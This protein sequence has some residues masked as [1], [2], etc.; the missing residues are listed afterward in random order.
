MTR[1]LPDHQMANGERG[2]DARAVLRYSGIFAAIVVPAGFIALGLPATVLAVW[3]I[4]RMIARRYHRQLVVRETLI[5]ALA[6]WAWTFLSWLLRELAAGAPAALIAFQLLWQAIALATTWAAY[7]WLSRWVIRRAL[8]S[9]SPVEQVQPPAGM[10]TRQKEQYAEATARS[11]TLGVAWLTVGAI[12]LP[13]VFVLA[14]IVALP[15]SLLGLPAGTTMFVI[16]AVFGLPAILGTWVWFISHKSA[17]VFPSHRLALWL[18]RFHRADLMEFPFASFLE[19]ASRGIAVPITLQDSTVTDARTAA[20]LRPEFHVL[21]A[22]AMACWFAF[23]V[24]AVATLASDSWTGR[25]LP[26][27][28]AVLALGGFF[29]LP[30]AI[31]R[32]GVL[33]LGTPRGERLAARLMDAIDSEQGVPQTLTVVSAPDTSWQSWVLR[34]ISRADAVLVDVTHLSANLHWELRTIA[35]RL[36]PEQLILAFGWTGE[37][38]PDLPADT[39]AELAGLLGET[40]LQRSQRFFYE[41]PSHGPRRRLFPTTV[42]RKGWLRLPK[43]DTA[44]YGQQ[45]AAALNVAFSASDRVSHTPTEPVPRLPTAAPPQRGRFRRDS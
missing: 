5:L 13:A 36:E 27:T 10:L 29:A 22:A 33:R 3:L 35:E 18:R 28:I 1:N 41:L 6:S 7:L 30:R 11:V 16:V 25:I 42:S 20:E 24:S 19:R 2:I 37:S 23:A 26:G 45:L 44:R 31:K 21:R 9:E 8:G 14:F 15:L 34:L 4:S 32:L 12:A 17:E 43:D 39:R 38:G 40:M